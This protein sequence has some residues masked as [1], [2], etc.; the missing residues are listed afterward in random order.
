MS[1]YLLLL[2]IGTNATTILKWLVARTVGASRTSPGVKAVCGA[3]TVAVSAAVAISIFARIKRL[4]AWLNNDP[5]ALAAFG[6][7][8]AAFYARLPSATE[9][10]VMGKAPARRRSK[11]S[12]TRIGEAPTVTTTS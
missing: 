8:E 10:A 1:T 9:A 4:F 5:K 6:R 2:A 12:S 3:L 7:A 11:P